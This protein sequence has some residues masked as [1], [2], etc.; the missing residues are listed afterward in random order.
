MDRRFVSYDS[1]FRQQ[2][3][4]L[5]GHVFGGS[6]AFNEAYFDWKYEQNPYLPEPLV[7]IALNGDRMVGMR[8]FYGARWV[9]GDPAA[10]AL[11]PVGADTA[12]APEYRGRWL[13][14]RMMRFASDDLAERGYHYAFN[15]S[16]NQAMRLLSLR[17]GWRRLAPFEDLQLVRRAPGAVSGRIEQTRYRIRR[18]LGLRSPQFAALDQLAAQSADSVSVAREARPEAMADLVARQRGPGIGH[19]RDRAFYAWRF[20]DPR[21]VYR[22]LFIANGADLEGFVVLHQPPGGGFVSIVDWCAE[23]TASRT[24]LLQALLRSGIDRIQIWAST[25]PRDF[26]EE[27]HA[28]G[29]RDG[30]H[31]DSARR[32]LAGMLIGATSDAP[33]E[34]WRLGGR[35]LLDPAEW[36]LR[37][38]YS[39]AY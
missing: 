25:L 4:D 34:S 5:R 30:G 21:F 18:R 14:Q 20:H 39:D 2:V 6:R 38:L 22:F 10:S 19:L 16:A 36:D 17:A 1:R 31:E 24:R 23:N 26:L 29:F 27:L 35:P 3:I 13:L 15:F 32:L 9:A 8:G 12:V 37:M 28:S 11:I 33:A 7:A